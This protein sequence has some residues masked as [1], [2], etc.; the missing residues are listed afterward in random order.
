V[1]FPQ[2]QQV[3]SPRFRIGQL[4]KSQKNL[5]DNPLWL[6]LNQLTQAM[7]QGG[8]TIE[9][10]KFQGQTLHV[11]VLSHDFDA[12]EALQTSLQ[13]AGVTV[14][15]SQASSHEKQVMATLELSL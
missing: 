11:T 15:Q 4:L 9:Q 13:K 14:K 6:L 3:I 1:F 7:Q 2:A 8:S 12:L 5:G 10:F